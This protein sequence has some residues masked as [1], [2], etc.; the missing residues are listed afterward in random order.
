MVDTDD[1]EPRRKLVKPLDLQQLSVGE[2]EEYI[3]S[4]KTE[5]SR[6]EDMIAKKEAHKSGVD[7]LFGGSKG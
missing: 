3:A 1:L 5:I 2:L 4:L 7:A 6:V